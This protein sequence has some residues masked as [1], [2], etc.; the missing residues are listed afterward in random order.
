MKS[1]DAKIFLEALE[2]LEKEKG[3]S[4]ESLLSTVEQALLAA[5]KKNYGEEENVEVEI[6]RETGD[7]KIYEVKTVVPTEDLYDAA[8]EISYDDALEIKKR[9]KIGEVI[10]IEV[11]CEEFRRNAIQ[12][13]KQ[14]VIQK[15][16]EAEREYIY[17]RFKVKE[18]DIINGIIRR[19]DERKNVFIEFDGIEAILPPVEQSPADT[20]RVG[21]RIKVYL[22]EVEKTN[23]F[24]KI[25]I[26]RKHEGLLRKLFELEIPE[27]T[28]GLIEIKAVAREAGSRA[29]V[30]VYSADPNI[31]TV[32]ACIGQKGL[33]IKNIVNELNGEKIDIVVWK[34]SIEEF[35]SAVLS[36]AKVVSVEVVEE[37]NTAR[38]IVDNSQLSLAIGKN[39]QNA[40]LAAK[41]TGMRVDIK[42]AD[43]V[44]EGE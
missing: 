44:E 36:P 4:K 16:R 28:S 38:V 3:I 39:G 23:K 9:V 21:E 8:I 11:N 18:H 22:A 40:R 32:G 12:N 26:S 35:V 41:L 7:V 24:P 33:R 42:T 2:E 13:G 6:D 31:D 14:I 43:R 15:V 30:A 29:K 17:D 37:E 10:R 19:I 27:I 20:Y 1:K 5:Y 25:V 34:E